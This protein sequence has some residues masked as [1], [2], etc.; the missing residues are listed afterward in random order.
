[1]NRPEKTRVTLVSSDY[2]PS[3]AELE[4]PI[5]MRKEDGSLPTMEELAQAVLRPVEIDW[6]ERPE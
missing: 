2:Q 4:A 6:T 5:D 3:K 1:M